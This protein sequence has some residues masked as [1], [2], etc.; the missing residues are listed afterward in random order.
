[1]TPNTDPTQTPTVDNSPTTSPNTDPTH[2]PSN[3]QEPAVKEALKFAEQPLAVRQEKFMSAA[4]EALN[5]T[6]GPY[7]TAFTETIGK[8]GAVLISYNPAYH[9]GEA[10]DIP[11]QV[12][13]QQYFGKKLSRN[14]PTADNPAKLDTPA[15]VEV[16]A[17]M[18]FDPKSSHDFANE[19]GVGI[20]DYGL[21]NTKETGYG[22]GSGTIEDIAFDDEFLNELPKLKDASGN[23]LPMRVVTYKTDATADAANITTVLVLVDKQWLT[24]EEAYNTAGRV[25]LKEYVARLATAQSNS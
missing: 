22:I 24:V 18:Y 20:P 19:V 25:G 23:E 8:T 5:A 3:E 6:D 4:T 15:A 1:M 21:L 13:G 16:L 2:S 17:G 9:P 10:D 14:V 7:T 11:E 12:L